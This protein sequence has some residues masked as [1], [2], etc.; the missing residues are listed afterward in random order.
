MGARSPLLVADEITLKGT[1]EG[2]P[3]RKKN[4]RS[5]DWAITGGADGGGQRKTPKAK[6]QKK[7]G[8]GKEKRRKRRRVL[9]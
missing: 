6:K 8:M 1:P 3:S 5:M 2:R 9:S 4:G 7:K